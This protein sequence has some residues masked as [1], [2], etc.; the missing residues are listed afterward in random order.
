MLVREPIRSRSSAA[1]P[2]PN[3]EDVFL[4]RIGHPLFR[5]SAKN[6]GCV[7]L[8]KLTWIQTNIFLREPMGAFGTIGVLL[9]A[10]LGAV[11]WRDPESRLI[12]SCR[13]VFI[14]R[15]TCPFSLRP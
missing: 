5:Y 8:L 3:I 9:S 6:D 15:V 11:V 2:F 12:Q 4:K 10:V 1:D 14:I 13:I 7:D